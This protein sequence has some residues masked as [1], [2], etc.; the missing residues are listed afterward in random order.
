MLKNEP[1]LGFGKSKEIYKTFLGR[2]EKGIVRWKNLTDIDRIKTEIVL[3]CISLQEKSKLVKSEFRRK[4]DTIWCKDYN[5]GTCNL[6]DNHE[7]LFQG[8]LVRV[9]HICRKCFTKKKEKIN[10]EKLTVNVLFMNDSQNLMPKIGI[11]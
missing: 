8:K 4:T 7:Q 5:R 9:N 10:R 11:P 1:K 2:I 6:L 3:K